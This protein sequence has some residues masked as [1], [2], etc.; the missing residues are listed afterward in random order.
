MMKRWL[1]NEIFILKITCE[2]G[3]NY[4]FKFDNL[5]SLKIE[6]NKWL[7]NIDE[8]PLYNIEIIFGE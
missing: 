2:M 3:F 7:K 5:K 8:T 6:L 1:M 4:N